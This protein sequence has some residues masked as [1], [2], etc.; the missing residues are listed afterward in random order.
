MADT[1]KIVSSNNNTIS[2]IVGLTSALAAKKPIDT[3]YTLTNSL[4]GNANSGS[5]AYATLT[6]G[7]NKTFSIANLADLQKH[8]YII[9]NDHA[10]TITLLFP[11]AANNSYYVNQFTLAQNLLCHVEVERWGDVYEWSVVKKLVT[12]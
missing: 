12:V 8:T 6:D 3:S 4:T 7:A 11:T 9:R 5:V 10:T 1:D 2:G